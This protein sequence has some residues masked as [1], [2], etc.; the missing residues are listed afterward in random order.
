MRRGIGV[1]EMVHAVTAERPQRASG[2]MAFHVLDIMQSILESSDTGRHVALQSTCDRPAALPTG[3]AA[4]NREV[5][6]IDDVASSGHT[7]ARAA[8]ALLAAGA[9]SVRVV[10]QAKRRSNSTGA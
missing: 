8:E 9:A 7:L 4:R 10:V 6:L 5:V 1:A 2:D 3:L